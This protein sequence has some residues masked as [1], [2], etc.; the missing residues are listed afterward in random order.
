MIDPWPTDEDMAEVCA[1]GHPLGRHE[2]G[3]EDAPCEDC[4][5]YRFHDPAACPAHHAGAHPVAT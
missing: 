4:A 1:C 3:S 2:Y 5:C